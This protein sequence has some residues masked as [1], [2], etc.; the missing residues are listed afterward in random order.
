[1]PRKW[2]GRK[3]DAGRHIPAEM[4][5]DLSPLWIRIAVAAMVGMAVGIE[6]ER[7]GH[8]VGPGQRFAG[9]RTFLLLGGVG[10]AA[11]WLMAS[12]LE[13]GASALL[14]GTA[15]LIV[16]AF[17]LSSRAH[18]SDA[19]T[20]VAA[21]LVLSL[22]VLAGLGQLAVASAAGVITVVALGEKEWIHGAVERLDARE[23]RAALQFA[24]LALVILPLLPDRTYGPWGGI[25][26]R[27][28]WIVVLIFSGLNFAG[29]VARRLVGASR[30]YT[31]TGAL[32]GLIS[33]TGVAL[34]FGRRSREIPEYAASLGLG[35]VAASTV[36]LPRL[37]V[38]STILNHAVAA[39]VLPLLLPAFGVGVLLIALGLWRHPPDTRDSI[40]TPNTDG[41]PLAL[42]S[43]L[44]MAVAFQVVLML[45]AVVR[46]NLGTTGIMATAAVLGLTDMDALA[47]SMNRMGSDPALT[48]VAARAIAVGVIANAVLKLGLSLMLGS[49]RFRLVAGSGL[50]LLA[51]TGAVTLLVALR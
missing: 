31:V 13:L 11:G 41:N 34:T 46:D 12:G 15:L 50:A 47:L 33:S 20:E 10:G 4:P 45:V 51:A 2:G 42:R 37:L 27:S 17:V 29:Y 22:G 24:V 1:M 3:P 7:S 23:L 40:A 32:G 44:L 43:A 35:A 30:G 49:S 8:H 48:T 39:A 6:R 21:L 26:P 5:S 38:L 9:V 18:G 14:L 16:S 36:L 25:N 19:T 28:L